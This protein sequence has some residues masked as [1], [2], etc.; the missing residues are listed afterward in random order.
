MNFYYFSKKFDSDMIKR[1]IEKKIISSLFKGKLIIILGPRQ[2]G[3]TTLIKSLL[4]NLNKKTLSLNGDEPDIREIMTKITSTKLK[5][6]TYGYEI[7]FIDEAQKIPD[8]GNTLKLMHDNFP[9]IQ[10]IA[11][12]SSSFELFQRTSEPLTGRKYEFMLF[13]LSFSEMVTHTNYIDE[14]RLIDYRLVYGYYPEIVTNHVESKTLLK[15]LVSSYLYKD[16]FLVD[17]IRNTHIIEKLVKALAL[18]VG[19]EVSFNELSRL[20]GIDKNT[21]EKYINALE[22]AFIVFR[23]SAYN[24]NIRTEIKKGKKFYF[25][26]NGVMN[27]IVGNFN[28]ISARENIGR[29]WENFVISERYKLLKYL[30]LDNEPYFWRT[31]QQQEIDYLEVINDKVLTYEI[32]WNPKTKFRLPKIFRDNYKIEEFKI[33]HKDNFEELLL[34][35]E[36]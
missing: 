6:I 17:N 18:Q 22:K 9:N 30:E 16:L 8:I 25:Y 35:L 19:N 20:I 33:I 29:L 12:G 14:K 27:T 3:K 26:D 7:L 24:K 11:T 1:M 23:L 4:E 28:P 5:Q 36:G 15:S 21:V 10:T 2:S 31:V 34:T 32:K 13:P